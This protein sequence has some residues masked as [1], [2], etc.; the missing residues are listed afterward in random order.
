M[1]HSYST[2]KWIKNGSEILLH[3]GPATGLCRIYEEQ[4]AILMRK[5]N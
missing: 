3:E 4:N 2:E 5:L 1:H